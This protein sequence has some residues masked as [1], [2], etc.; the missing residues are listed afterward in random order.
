MAAMLAG[1]S[2][3]VKTFDSGLPVWL[4]FFQPRMKPASLRLFFLLL[5]GIRFG[6]RPFSARRWNPR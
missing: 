5:V 6:A 2:E 3:R 4:R 1:G